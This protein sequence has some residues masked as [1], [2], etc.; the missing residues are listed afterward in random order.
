MTLRP[1]KAFLAQD[2]GASL[3]EAALIIP[4]FTIIIGGLMDF[5][6]AYGEVLTA[7]KSLRDAT[8][9]LSI[10][11]SGAVCTWGKTKALNLAGYGNLAGTGSPVIKGWTAPISNHVTLVTPT[12][13]SSSTDVG[14]I[15]MKATVPYTAIVWPMVGLPAS[16]NFEVKHEERWIGQ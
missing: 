10:L 5:G 14:V 15:S 9:Y 4:V 6:L 7:Q 2:S 13:C 11:P 16:I 12:T 1:L 8:R 3:V